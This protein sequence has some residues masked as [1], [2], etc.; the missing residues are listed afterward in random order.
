MAPRGYDLGKR[1]ESVAETKRRILAATLALHNEQGV[2]ATTLPEV[3]RRADVALGTVYKHFPTVDDLV[4]ACG[5]HVMALIKPPGPDIFVGIEA[6]PDRI[7]KLV[8]EL[9]AMYERG[10]RQIAVAR[11]EQDEVPA[12]KAFVQQD[13]RGHEQLL[14]LALGQH[15]L[16][17]PELRAALALTDFYVWKAFSEKRVP[18]QQAAEMITAA[19]LANI[20]GASA[21]KETTQ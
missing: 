18:T 9:F 4:T 10:A 16:A 7:G 20:T 15:R 17:A 19:V 3:A 5:G 14:R 13:A 2:S 6:L 21:R 1:A 11:C 8:H 12:L